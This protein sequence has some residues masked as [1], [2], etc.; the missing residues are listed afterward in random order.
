MFKSLL[1][2][3]DL[4]D[5]E[6]AIRATQAATTLAHDPEAVLHVV[7]VVPDD[8]MA[9]VSASFGAEH[10]AE[11]MEKAKENLDRWAK[12][13]LLDGA[14]YELHV[15]RGTVYDQILKTASDLEVEVIVVGAHRPAFRDY[16]IGPNAARVARHAPQSVFVV[17]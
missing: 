10:S 2:A 9:M 1:L 5:P 12:G 16:L 6:G 8:G 7:N 14:S 3:V 4:N 13:N 15:A 17:R 11:V